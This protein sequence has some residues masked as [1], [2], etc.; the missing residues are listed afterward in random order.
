M[1]PLNAEAYV[2]LVNLGLKPKDEVIYEIIL[3]NNFTSN[4]EWALNQLFEKRNVKIDIERLAD[5]YLKDKPAASH[6]RAR[7]ILDYPIRL[8]KLGAKP[9]MF[10]NKVIF[11]AFCTLL[12]IPQ[13]NGS[14][15]FYALELL[16]ESSP[17]GRVVNQPPKLDITDEMADALYQYKIEL[18]EAIK[19]MPQDEASRA[20]KL[21]E[22]YEQNNSV[23]Q[24]SELELEKPVDA[25]SESDDPA[26]LEIPHIIHPDSWPVL[27]DKLRQSENAEMIEK[28][29]KR[30]LSIASSYS[31]FKKLLCIET[32][33]RIRDIS[34]LSNTLAC[35]RISISLL[36]SVD[37]IAINDKK[38]YPNMLLDELIISKFKDNN[39]IQAAFHILLTEFKADVK[40]R[41][42]ILMSNHFEPNI[43]M[44]L[45]RAGANP[46]ELFSNVKLSLLAFLSLRNKP[47][48]DPRVG[49]LD[50]MIKELVE[51]YHA[52]LNSDLVEILAIKQINHYDNDYIPAIMQLIRLGAPFDINKV[53]MRFI[54]F[55]CSGE[56]NWALKEL[57][58]IYNQ[59]AAIPIVFD[60]KQFAKFSADT[61]RGIGVSPEKF[62]VVTVINLVNQGAPPQMFIAKDVLDALYMWQGAPREYFKAMRDRNSSLG[63]V[64]KPP[65]I[66]LKSSFNV[67]ESAR[68]NKEF[69][70]RLYKVL[71]AD[72]HRSNNKLK[73][74]LDDGFSKTIDWSEVIEL[75]KL[76]GANPNLIDI[77]FFRKYPFSFDQLKE[78]LEFGFDVSSRDNSMLLNFFPTGQY[79]LIALLI[80]YGMSTY[81]TRYENILDVII[82]FSIYKM[83]PISEQLICIR[84]LLNCNVPFGNKSEGCKL[85]AKWLFETAK[86]ED[87]TPNILIN[88]KQY[89]IELLAEIMTWHPDIAFAALEQISE[90]PDS[91]LGTVFRV[92]HVDR[93]RGSFGQACTEYTKRKDAKAALAQHQLESGKPELI[94]TKIFNGLSKQADFTILAE[95]LYKKAKSAEI[96]DAICLKLKPHKEAL[97]KAI[98]FMGI[99]ECIEPLRQISEDAD[100]VLGRVFRAGNNDRTVG[101]FGKACA[102][103]DKRK[104]GSSVSFEIPK[105]VNVSSK[106][107][108]RVTM[109]LGN[110]FGEKPASTLSTIEA[111]DKQET[112]STHRYGNALG[113]DKL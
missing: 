33:S 71:D 56:N 8:I 109:F 53:L 99:N 1:K 2:L 86:V 90:Q 65:A 13:I 112:A 81:M 22:K 98:L 21:I 37:D 111:D 70:I 96:T 28:I 60:I 84:S 29:E 15:K 79:D 45:V 58:E 72:D 49:T 62:I 64:V 57:F 41:L 83:F 87:L 85:I 93:G 113:D 12:K 88:L 67:A 63:K 102:E 51:I 19:K 42:A 17:L 5:Y 80:E 18:L 78:M 30:M 54:S 100:S 36:R 68:A 76:E 59:K 69:F 75:I 89:K 32:T 16:D 105:T 77:Y 110:V 97:L 34:Q 20:L 38:T 7:V 43:A 46:H 95:W 11:Q 92:G 6:M 24:I 48:D 44:Q 3:Q 82:R 104:P 106:A 61:L 4:N 9:D 101:M 91:V 52:D 73:Q 40:G 47:S 31:A 14:K 39:E 10:S 25:K 55:R 107:I 35:V 26:D 23:V 103:Y 66:D 94:L 50:A 74:K 108:S 27:L